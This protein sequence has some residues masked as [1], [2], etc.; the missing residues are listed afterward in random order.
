MMNVRINNIPCILFYDERI[1]QSKAPAGYAYSY[2]LR[3]TEDDW[4]M[5]VNIEKF[6]YVNFF[7][8]IFTKEPFDFGSEIYIE[9]E[10]FK[11]ESDMVEFV[12]TNKFWET[13]F[14]PEKK[15]GYARKY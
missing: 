12:A 11:M 1:P 9:V 10:Q 4:T 13:M 2:H 3:H 14:P 7:G 15:N 6:V 8:T 5:P